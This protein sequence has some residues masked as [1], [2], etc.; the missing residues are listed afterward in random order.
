[1]ARLL[2]GKS[3]K[4]AT[5]ARNGMPLQDSFKIDEVSEDVTIIAVAD[6]HGSEKCPKSKNGSQIAVNAFCKV[7][8]DYL[9]NYENQDE[10]ITYL[11]REGELK[12]SQ[13]V[14]QEW[15]RRVRKSFNDSKAEKPKLED[16]SVNWKSVYQMYGTTLIG[17]LITSTFIFA[18]QIGDGDAV[19]V[20][21]E[22]ISPIVE[23]EKMLGT[24]T[25]SL[26]KMDAWRKAVSVVRRKEDTEGMPYL[27]MLST[28]GFSIKS[29]MGS[30]S[31]L[32]NYGDGSRMIFKIVGCTEKRMHEI[33]L[34]EDELKIIPINLLSFLVF[35]IL[36]FL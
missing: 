3:V 10:L 17:L 33:N 26:S 18:F 12:F 1:M 22:T 20:D 4:G 19:M 29:H 30:P 32:F 24:E 13:D 27:Y 23:S 34:I 15:Q 36:N 35:V 2:F 14:C 28:D 16:G 25:H 21:G 6:G 7:M 11:N 9:Q 8:R 31:S 5:H